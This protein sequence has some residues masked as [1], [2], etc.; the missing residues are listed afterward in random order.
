MHSYSSDPA[1]DADVYWSDMEAQEAAAEAQAQHYYKANLSE[2]EI[3]STRQGPREQ[4][5]FE[6]LFQD[7]LDEA[8]GNQALLAKVRL[9]LLTNDDVE[10]GK[11]L[12]DSLKRF[13]VT[14][15][16]KEAEDH[17]F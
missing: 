14:V 8:N 15:S 6:G 2:I 12:I 16:I 17:G 10:A 7:W 1:H 4:Y 9:A 11:E 5:K 3:I 13:L